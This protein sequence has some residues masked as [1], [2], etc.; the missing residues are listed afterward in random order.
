[1]PGPTEWLLI[2]AGLLLL[3]GAKKL[4]ELARSMGSSVTQFKKGLKE[5]PERLDPPKESEDTPTET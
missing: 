4:P 5:P 2:F 1:M 3:F